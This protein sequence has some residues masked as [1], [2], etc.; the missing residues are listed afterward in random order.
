MIMSPTFNAQIKNGNPI[1]KQEP[2]PQT[3]FY[4]LI[5]QTKQTQDNICS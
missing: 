1:Q 3:Q 2:V 5:D 4:L